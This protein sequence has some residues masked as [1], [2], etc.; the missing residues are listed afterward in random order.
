MNSDMVQY[1]GVKCSDDIPSVLTDDSYYTKKKRYVRKDGRCN[2]VVRH[3]PE[4]WLLWVTDIFTTLVEIRWRV[5]FLTFAL[6]YIL[7]WLLFG[8]LFWIIALTHG[9][10]KEPTNEPCMYEVRS[11]TAAFLFSLETQTTIGYGFRGMSENCMIA[12]I[13]VTIQ[14]VISVFID[15]FVIGVAVAKMASA[16]KRAQTVGFSKCAVISLRDGHLCLSWRVVDF[17][18]NH[19]VEGTAYAQLVQHMAHACGKIDI[20]Y[21]DLIIEESNIILATPTTIVHKISPDSPLYKVSLQDLRKEN[22][23]LVM[24]FT[25][26]DDCTGILHQSHTSYTP[27]E[28]LWGQHFQEMIRVTRKNYRVDYALFNHTVKVLV[29]ELSAENY[30]LKKCSPQPKH[31]P[32][33]ISSPTAAVELV[34]WNGLDAEKASTSSAVQEY[35]L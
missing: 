3:V 29:P 28:I 20:S 15:T 10:M 31:K 22:F 33:H 17:R 7:S 35:K 1:S 4:Q 8:I 9:D 32:L 6:S 26:T 5:M 12:I 24:S 16:R 34:N 14:D 2:M 11:F 30:D 19:M 18:K 27:S 25:Y 23:E 21:K 13:F